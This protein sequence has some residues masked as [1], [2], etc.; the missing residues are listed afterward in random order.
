[1]IQSV[2]QVGA[3]ISTC[4]G[5]SVQSCILTAQANSTIFLFHSLT[6]HPYSGNFCFSLKLHVQSSMIYA[7]LISCKMWSVQHSLLYY[8]LMR[9]Y[10]TSAYSDTKIES[11]SHQMHVCFSTDTMWWGPPPFCTY[12]FKKCSTYAGKVFKDKQSNCFHQLMQLSS[13][14]QKEK[15]GI[16]NFIPNF[17]RLMFNGFPKVQWFLTSFLYADTVLCI[18]LSDIYSGL[19][20][21][22]SWTSRKKF[23]RWEWDGLAGGNRLALFQENQSRIMGWNRGFLDSRLGPFLCYGFQLPCDNPKYPCGVP[24]ETTN[25]LRLL[26]NWSLSVS[27]WRYAYQAFKNLSQR[28]VLTEDRSTE[29]PVNPCF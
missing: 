17:W 19:S 8:W 25:V 9:K 18:Y 24:F 28:Y 23:S 5:Y 22:F 10:I 13:R 2:V 3:L 29:S 12:I 21:G 26:R 1:M 16:Y 4:I 6:L 20:Q 7:T 11:F 27:L 14:R 15:N